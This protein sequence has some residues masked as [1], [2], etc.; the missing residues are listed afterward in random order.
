MP[1]PRYVSTI[2]FP[3]KINNKS[4]VEEVEDKDFHNMPLKK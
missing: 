3:E 1:K 4:S 2:D